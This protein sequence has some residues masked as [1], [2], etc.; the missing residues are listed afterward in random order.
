[1]SDIE[2]LQAYGGQLAE[3]AESAKSSAEKQ[4]VYVNGDASTDVLTESGPVPSLAKQAVLGQAKIT[5]SLAEVATQMAGAMTYA[6]TAL[7]LA[8]TGSGGYFSVPSPESS[9]YLILYQNASG[10][11]VEA[12]RY[13]SALINSLTVNV[14]KPYPLKPMVRDGILSEA[15]S[16]IQNSFLD[17]KVIGARPGRLYRAEWIGTGTTALGGGPNYQFLVTEYVKDNYALNSEK[18]STPVIELNDIPASSV[19]SGDIITR[20]FKSSRIDGVVVVLT[21]RPKALPAN[22]SVQ[23]NNPSTLAG[24]SWVIDPAVYTPPVP[25]KESSLTI[26][27]DKSFPLK[28]AMR[29]TGE[30]KPVVTSPEQSLFRLGVLDIKAVGVPAGYFLRLGWYG[31]GTTALGGGPN[32]GMEFELAEIST[33]AI[34]GI[35]TKVVLFS[36]KDYEEAVVSGT[37]VTRTYSAT[38]RD[39][40][41]ISITYD[42]AVFAPTVGTSVSANSSGNAGYSWIVDPSCCLPAP[43]STKIA[44]T[45]PLVFSHAALET[46]VAW[47]FN[48]TFDIRVAIG[49]YGVNQLNDIG[50]ISFK[51]HGGGV[52]SLS[53]A[54]V[55]PTP[56]GTDWVGPYIVNAD[57]NGSGSTTQFTGGN[58]GYDGAGGAATA[59]SVYRRVFA[60]GRRLIAGETGYAS[61][62]TFQWE[63]LV[64]GSNTRDVPRNILREQHSFSVTPFSIETT[65]RITALEAITIKRYH[66]LQAYLRGFN[67]TVHSFNGQA[68]GRIPFANDTNSGP[69]SRFP[70]VW[71]ATVEGGL[72]GFNLMLWLD[73]SY[74]IGNSANLADTAPLYK[75]ASDKIYA[76]IVEDA[77]PLALP[78]GKSVSW[79]G[80]YSLAP[81]FGEDIDFGAVFM[82]A[83]KPVVVAAIT[84]SGSGRVALP[85]PDNAG[86]EISIIHG[87]AMVGERVESDGVAVS[88]HKYAIVALAL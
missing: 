65:G 64:Q 61:R 3:A 45:G 60:D 10:V 27:G 68:G 25:V 37:V 15:P 17:M 41:A 72:Y 84:Q 66:G 63:N 23:M 48:D 85:T 62:V 70:D 50:A 28:S 4:H 34:T 54:W 24:W 79:R 71:G 35:A 5:A 86:R 82:D 2:S 44:P 33:F 77:K 83:G 31:N 12:K 30:G 46:F 76:H 69:K 11:A 88:T 13:P 26:N 74:G 55:T 6:N 51:P 81:N 43:A 8:G 21:Y 18:G 9:E 32:Y 40:L 73:R 22:S 49:R 78:A 7:G 47:R 19:E 56:R 36:D 58:H 80:G 20:T 67:G 53:G 59:E 52:L 57:L 14:G 75:F 39:G 1:M 42:K 38:S 29:G 87:S 16:S